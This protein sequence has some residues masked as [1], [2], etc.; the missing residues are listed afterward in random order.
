MTRRVF[1]KIED[2]PDGQFDAVVT[3]EPSNVLR[4][5]GFASLAEAEEWVEGLRFVMAAIGAPVARDNGV[6]AAADAQ[7][8]AAKL[9]P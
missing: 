7:S 2:R 6:D 1:Y 9:S 8:A 5:E 3:I 4:R